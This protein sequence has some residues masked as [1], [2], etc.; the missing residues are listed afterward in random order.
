[1]YCKCGQ[2]FSRCLLSD[3]GCF[4][5]VA[6]TSEHT[7]SSMKIE[8]GQRKARELLKSLSL[9]HSGNDVLLLISYWLELVTWPY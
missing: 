3:L 5:I 2:L 9:S 8:A 1:M 4:N 7:V 6:T